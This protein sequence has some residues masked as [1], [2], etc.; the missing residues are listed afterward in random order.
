MKTSKHK[1]GQAKPRGTSNQAAGLSKIGEHVLLGLLTRAQVARELSTCNHT[2]ARYT[3]KGLLPAVVI[4]P[5]CV[6][7]RPEDLR[8]FVESALVH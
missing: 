3:K 2:V 4:G 6:R 8:K 5:R 1:N 7:Y